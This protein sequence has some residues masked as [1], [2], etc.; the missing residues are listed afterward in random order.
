VSGPGLEFRRLGAE[1]AREARDTVEAVFRGAYVADIESGDPF[2][3]PEAF[4][5]R[6][7]SY[8][9]N[10]RLDLVIAYQDGLP[11]G[12]SWGWPLAAGSHWWEGLTSE[13]E[14]GFTVEDG[15]RTF[16][17]SEVMVAREYTGRGIA[18]ALHDELLQRRS[19]QRATLLAEPDNA[20]AYRAYVKWGW[21]KVSQI[22]PR[23]PD[24]PLFDVLML[25]L[26]L[27]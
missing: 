9:A 23:W 22:R 27:H 20:S 3:T 12:Q 4:M 16:A 7:D 15:S 13:P 25:P 10:P 17:F 5:G 24:A 26:P 8:A 1:G 6:F 2:D 18:H 19:E 11:V 21:Q 14:P